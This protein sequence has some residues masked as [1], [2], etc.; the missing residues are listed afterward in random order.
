[1]S[2]LNLYLFSY[3]SIRPKKVA[4]IL[5]FCYI[6]NYLMFYYCTNMLTLC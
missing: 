6:P 2:G 4:A 5:K 3:Q 1:M